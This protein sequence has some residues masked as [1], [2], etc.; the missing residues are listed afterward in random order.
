MPMAA[1]KSPLVWDLQPLDMEKLQKC[2]ASL[3]LNKITN[4]PITAGV[5]GTGHNSYSTYEGFGALL[6]LKK[7]L[8]LTSLWIRL[9]IYWA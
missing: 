5:V 6:F 2:S 8:L 7:P 9:L 3:R 1:G 4:S